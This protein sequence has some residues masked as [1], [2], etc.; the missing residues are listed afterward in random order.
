[1]HLRTEPFRN[2]PKPLDPGCN[3]PAC[4]RYSRAY[5]RHLTREK[6]TLGGRLAS[7]HNLRFYLRLLEEARAAIAERRF[8]GLR[9]EWERSLRRRHR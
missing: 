6:E 3:C 1:L 5:L 4:V 7:L 2:D 9:S 8:S